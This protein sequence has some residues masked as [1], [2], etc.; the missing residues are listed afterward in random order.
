MPAGALRFVTLNLWGENGPV[1][2]R[3]ALVAEELARLAPDVVALQEVRVAPGTGH[4]AESLAAACGLFTVF[5]PT[6]SWGGGEEGLALLSRF[7]IGD[8]SA[9]TLPHATTQEGRGVLSVRLDSPFGAV[10]A[11]VTHLSYREHE[12]T[13]R[14][15]QLQ[16]I[17]AI[18]AEKATSSP[19]PHVLMGDLNAA[20]A[21]DEIR[22]LRGET[23]LGGRRVYYQDAWDVVY[24]R[25]PGYTWAKENPFRAGMD[26]LRADRR[27]DYVFVSA[28]RRD[29]RGRIAHVARVFDRPDGEGIYPSDHYGV[30]ADVQM[31]PT[32]DA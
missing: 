8:S 25:E 26:W 31:A 18:M 6:T 12:G 13:K 24:P 14:E 19:N 23:T 29:G 17:E 4:Q 9:A 3:M 7:P 28:S 11:H 15:D 22:W 2:R 20:P 1:A 16:F 21:C 30:M 32:E 27:L 10:W 5:A